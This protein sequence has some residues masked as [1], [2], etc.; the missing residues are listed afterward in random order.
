MPAQAGKFITGVGY[1]Y[2]EKY[3]RDNEINPLPFGLSII[4]MLA[5]RGDRLSVLGPR[6]S[7]AVL[8]GLV[9]VN[10]NVNVAG[11][12]YKANTLIQRDTAIHAGLSLRVPFFSLRYEH[13]VS[14]T[15]NGN[16][17]QATLRAPLK[18]SEKIF[19]RL[20]LTQEFVSQKY[21]KYYYQVERNE[22]G[23]FNYYS[24]DKEQN[25]IFNFNGSYSLSETTS[26]NLNW[27]HRRFGKEIANS[28]TIRLKNYNTVGIFWNYTL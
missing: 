4:P 12:R 28:P 23:L 22:V 24:P 11:D 10:L 26:L 13:D 20:S 5:Y 27:S 21:S 6:V 3:R 17:I 14:S 19:L 16:V 1:L 8:K 7:Y 18:V 2:P 9:G 15:H 25:I